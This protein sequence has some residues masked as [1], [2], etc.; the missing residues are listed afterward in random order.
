M[1]G[2][3]IW[4]KK[5]KLGEQV[6]ED[7][8]LLTFKNVKTGK[9]KFP[10]ILVNAGT[11]IYIESK[12]ILYS[13]V[14]ISLLLGQIKNFDGKIVFSDGICS[15]SN[16][17]KMSYISNSFF[18]PDVENIEALVYYTAIC[19]GFKPSKIYNDFYRILKLLNMDYVLNIPFSDINFNSRKKI[20]TA[21]TLSFPM[22]LII[23]SEPFIDIELEA[24]EVFFAEINRLLVDGSSFVV[25]AS[26]ADNLKYNLFY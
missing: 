21:L 5:E 23:L 25:L 4:L 3:T 14:F 26:E 11:C 16:S 1:V 17:K 9:Y 10:D 6:R 8:A 15:I 12:D 13:N 18:F 2:N 22:L 7:K 20:I 19:K 24:K